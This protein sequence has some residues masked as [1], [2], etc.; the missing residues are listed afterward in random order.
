MA[1]ESRYWAA[2]LWGAPEEAEK[3][4]DCDEIK[5]YAFINHNNDKWLE[6]ASEPPK[7]HIHLIFYTPG[8]MCPDT[9]FKLISRVR[10]NLA[11]TCVELL[12][13][14]GYFKYLTHTDEESVKAGKQEYP[15]TDIVTDS[16][17]FWGGDTPSGKGQDKPQWFDEFFAMVMQQEYVKR[18]DL[19]EYAL[20]FG[21]DF[22]YNYNKCLCLCAD[23]LGCRPNDLFCTPLERKAHNS[24]VTLKEMELNTLEKYRDYYVKTIKEDII[25]DIREELKK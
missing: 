11:N 24:R 21:K 9:A 16:A 23:I 2:V 22:A 8:K 15:V 14:K 7:A 10:P 4:V 6:G 25:D 3:V 1:V 13:P 18:S 20:R 19:K 17:G 12:N 5:H